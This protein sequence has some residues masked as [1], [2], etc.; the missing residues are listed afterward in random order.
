MKVRKEN[1]QQLMTKEHASVISGAN[2]SEE[3]LCEQR[4]SATRPKITAAVNA[5]PRGLGAVAGDSFMKQTPPGKTKFLFL[6]SRLCDIKWDRGMRSDWRT[7]SSH[8][9]AYQSRA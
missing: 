6:S 5:I 1:K 2:S 9:E 3:L 8:T 4:V 7:Q